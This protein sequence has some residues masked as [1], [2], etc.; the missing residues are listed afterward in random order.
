[1]GQSRS[2]HAISILRSTATWRSYQRS[3]ECAGAKAAK[4]RICSTA[5]PCAFGRISG[6]W[7]IVHDHASVQFYMDGAPGVPRRRL[8]ELLQPVRSRLAGVRPGGGRVQDPCGQR[9]PIADVGAAETIGTSFSITASTLT[10]G[11]GGGT[12]AA[13]SRQPATRVAST[14]QH[15]CAPPYHRRGASH[16]VRPRWY[17]CVDNR[18]PDS[19]LLR[20]K[21]R[22]PRSSTARAQ[23]DMICADSRRP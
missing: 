12:T 15:G 13:V 5:Q 6:R 23:G 7:R 17:R 9:G 22:P 14:G 2:M 8:R 19:A 11:G 4:I 3:T 21:G 18:R 16:C 10:A 20:G 1:M